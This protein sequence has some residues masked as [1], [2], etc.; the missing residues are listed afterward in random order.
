MHDI[1][2]IKAVMKVLCAVDG[3][4]IF[5]DTLAAEVELRL[6]RPL[7]TQA[8]D[9]A[10]VFCRDRGWAQCRKDLFDLPVW[11]VTEAGRSA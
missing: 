3:N 2:L 5:R 7:T 6:Q 9:D 1:A 10:L 11:T 8:L 4:P